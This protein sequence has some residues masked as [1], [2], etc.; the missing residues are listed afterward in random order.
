MALAPSI[1]RAALRA[2]PAIWCG[3]ADRPGAAPSGPA[4]FP[5]RSPDR[6]KRPLLRTHGTCRSPQHAQR[7]VSRRCSTI[8][9]L[10]CRQMLKR[11][12]RPRRLAPDRGISV[13]YGAPPADDR[14]RH[15][16]AS[17]TTPATGRCSIRRGGCPGRNAPVHA[18]RRAGTRFPYRERLRRVC[19]AHGLMGTPP[20]ERTLA[21]NAVY[22]DAPA[23]RFL[24]SGCA[25]RAAMALAAV[26]DQLDG[27][28]D[29][30]QIR[31]QGRAAASDRK[32]T[33]AIRLPA[34]G[35]SP[36][37]EASHALR[38]RRARRARRH[39]L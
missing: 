29:R 37:V 21:I 9:R 36:A 30:E 17:R 18:D 3:L 33:L 4:A 24:S 2:R 14:P 25:A 38:E 7:H 12:A 5:C 22:P 32:A 13:L 20:G 35:A 39:A 10:A 19:A 23:G 31:P 28:G 8:S 15:G 26:L 34:A 6:S 27:A 16:S 1:N 11:A